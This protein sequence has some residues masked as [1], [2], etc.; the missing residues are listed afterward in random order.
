MASDLV[1]VIMP[2][3]KAKPSFLSISIQSILEQKFSN[4]ELI[5]VYEKSSEKI[6]E[7]LEK[8][9]EENSDDHRLKIIK[10][11]EKGL[12]NSLNLGLAKAK[13]QYIARMDSDDISEKNRL[14][15]QISFI[16]ESNND[17]VGSWALSISEEGKVL[18]TIEP[19]VTHL[20]IR[21]K[22]M[23][24]NPFLHPSILFRKEIL[25]KVGFY[26]PKFNGAEDYDL[27]FRVMSENFRVSN[28]PKFLL[29][30]RETTGSFMRGGNWKLQ[31]S[32]YL[33]VKKNAMKNLGFSIP[34]D[35][36]YYYLST[37]TRFVSPKNA[38]LLKKK[39][40]YNKT[41]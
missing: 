6:D 31:R 40:G 16:K 15:E 9:F 27:Y 12:A 36:F 30:L 10:S 19:P 39:I 1:S 20:E 37:F 22:I 26:N 18:G 11:N 38:Y 14:E 13:G 35:L 28:M 41:V 33:N 21:K 4:L 24:H 2:V 34:R 25:E 7:S 17:L 32:I 5:I 29:R 8:I 3:W 23:F